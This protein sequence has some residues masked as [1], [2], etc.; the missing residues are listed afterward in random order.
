MKFKRRIW[1]WINKLT[2]KNNTVI[3]SHCVC[4]WRTLP[5][6]QPQTQLVYSLM[7]TS[8][9]SYLNNTVNITIYIHTWT[10]YKIRNT[11]LFVLNRTLSSGFMTG[12]F[13]LGP[14]SSHIINQQVTPPAGWWRYNN[15]LVP[16]VFSWSSDLMTPGSCWGLY[17]KQHDSNKHRM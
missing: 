4:M 16:L 11:F 13:W 17:R 8:L 15:W 12:K 1:D 2:L 7:E 14:I 5:P 10:W 9:Y 6:L 3:L